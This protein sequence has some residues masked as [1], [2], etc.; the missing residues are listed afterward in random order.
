MVHGMSASAR[1]IAGGGV[2]LQFPYREPLIDALREAVPPRFRRWNR[3]AKCWLVQGAYAPTAVNLLLEYFPR[4]ETPNE[5]PRRIR[6]T[7]ARTETSPALPLPDVARA[8][9]APEPDALTI[10]VRCPKCQHRHD[11]PVRVITQAAT[12]VARHETIAPEFAFVCT[13]CTTL[14]IVSMAPAPALAVAS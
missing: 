12:T 13:S 7:P 4:A 6:S 3:D 10:S 9:D 14:L 1:T 11:Q 2:A 8:D 5:Q